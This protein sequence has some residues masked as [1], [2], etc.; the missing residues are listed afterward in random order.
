M[1]VLTLI[2]NV[3]VE[4]SEIYNNVFFKLYYYINYL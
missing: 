4:L 1:I 3:L 2:Y